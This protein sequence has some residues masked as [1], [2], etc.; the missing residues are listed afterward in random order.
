MTLLTNAFTSY[1]VVGDREDLSDIIY[2]VSPTDVPFLA[3]IPRT[4]AK[5]TL[6][7]WLTDA[8]ASASQNAQ[9][10]GDEP[11]AAST[12]AATRLSNT[13]QI[14]YK[15]P[16]VT[17]TLLA[18]DVAGQKDALAH[19]VFKRTLE[20]RRDMENDLLANTAEDTGG[21]TSARKYGGVPSWIATNTSF[22]TSG[23][24]G[25][26]GNTAATDGTQRAFTE[27]LL[28]TVLKSCWDNG[29]DPDCV[30]VGSWNKQQIS[31]FT[32]NATRMIGAGDEKLV[33]SVSIYRSDFGDLEIIP[34]RFQPSRTAFVLQKDMWAVSYLRP[35]S[36][37]KLAKNGDSERRM[38]IAEYTLES[39]N[40]LAS[41]AVFD[42]TTS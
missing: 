38:V 6:H 16:A 11:S 29:G 27:D 18:T 22:G 39:R 34:N 2:M 25:S 15:V 13:C 19:Q 14:S 32:G 5:Q 21:A 40:E 41:G 28:K 8:L 37:Q 23:S 42:L 4:K 30:M 24:A 20:L 12:T 35:P 9:L 17:G 10:E 36:L 1:S 26:L 33:A 31:A 7:E 3:S